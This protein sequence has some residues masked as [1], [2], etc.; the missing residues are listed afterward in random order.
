M[1]QKSKKIFNF[2]KDKKVGVFCDDANLYQSYLKYN[3]RID[4]KKFQNFLEN[5]CNLQFINYYIAIPA[6]ND[7]SYAG[8]Q[9]FLKKIKAYVNI[10]E[11]K[12]KYTP[13]AGKI[14]KKGDVDIEIALDVIRAIDSLDIVI[15]VSGDSDFHELKNYII[16]DKKKNIIFWA[17]EKNMAWELKY[18]WHLYLD[19]F[20]NKI[21]KRFKSRK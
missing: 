17:F 13:V 18:C 21:L 15:L 7:A 12:L 4:F 8:T 3:W 10:K 2:L 20:K 9:K 19:N 14:I 11:K 16:K 6:K 5:H 1:D